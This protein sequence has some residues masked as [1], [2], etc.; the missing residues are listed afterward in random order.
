[1]NDDI[2]RKDEIHTHYTNISGTCTNINCAK[3]PIDKECTNKLN[4]YHLIPD[5]IK[6]EYPELFI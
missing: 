2:I 3:C 1:M 5:N 4:L 6:N